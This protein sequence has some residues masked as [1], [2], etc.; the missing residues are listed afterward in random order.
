MHT[1]LERREGAYFAYNGL[2]ISPS[3]QPAELASI[4][5]ACSIDDLSVACQLRPMHTGKHTLRRMRHGPAIK[6]VGRP[7]LSA[8]FISL[9]LSPLPAWL[10]TI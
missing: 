4:S 9:T 3:P 8:R 5:P 1:G 6:R 2:L 7:R 10:H